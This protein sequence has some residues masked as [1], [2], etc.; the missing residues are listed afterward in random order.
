VLLIVDSHAKKCASELR[1][2]HDH[3]YEACG[4]IKPGSL[5][6]EII[7]TAKKEVASLKQDNLV[8]LWTGANNISRNNSKEA[9]KIVSYFMYLL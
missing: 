6:S 8:I 7:K 2:N 5:S 3:N 9:L 4:F 1:H